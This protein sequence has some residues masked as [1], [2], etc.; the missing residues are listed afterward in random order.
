MVLIKVMTEITEQPKTREELYEKI[1]NSSKDS[2]ILD[3][4]IRLGFWPEKG[5]IPNDPADEIRRLSELN[6]KFI[7]LKEQNRNLSN[8]KKLL[9]EL[10]KQRL[11]ESKLEQ[12]ETK[13]RHEKE[14]KAR[15][16]EWNK[17]KENEIIY[18]GENISKG[19]NEQ[20]CSQE[21]LKQYNLTEYNNADEIAKAMNINVGLLRFL[22]FSRK[23]AP[24]SHY[25]R[26]K[27]QKKSG[28]YRFI[29]APMPK[30]KNAQYWIKDNILEKIEIHESVHGFRKE[31]SI[32]TNA[33]PHI[34]TK[35]VIN[36][37]LENFFPTIGYN[38]VKGLF[39]SIGYSDSSSTIFALLCTE[40]D[41]EEVE[42]DNKTWFVAL[43][44]RFL[45]QGA[46]TSP[47]ITNIMCRRL[48]KRLNEIAEKYAFNYTR[49]AD[50]LTFSAKSESSLENIGNVLKKAESIIV[51]EGFKINTN[52]TKV[53]RYS[54][55]Q[56][57][58]GIVVNKKLNIDRETLKKFRATL[59]QIEKDGIEN[60][61]WGKSNNLI[62]SIQGYANFVSSVNPE[63]GKI[64][65]EQ[66]KRIIAKHNKE[67]YSEELK[68][69]KNSVVDT[70]TVLPE[71][72]TKKW[73]KLF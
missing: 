30:L 59:Y 23:V 73:W 18:L 72:K 70:K 56:E 37:D 14:R 49:Y 6:K 12:K 40:P 19:L 60:K 2:Y 3:D 61:T 17:K 68:D 45:P 31:H 52:K 48:D 57:V 24:V 67:Q 66:I 33:K 35:A 9:Q 44:E 27:I 4:M 43:S 29:S 7:K 26:F 13:L 25:K 63:K 1:K 20:K 21:R 32:I 38:R 53:L 5:E 47:I 41:I 22:A 15:A 39:K 55:Q 28:G 10:R 62:Q 16:E 71:N 58:T 34:S 65:Q 54:R 8:E 50:D 36:L 51:H 46:P 42:L 69:K 64:F 11:A